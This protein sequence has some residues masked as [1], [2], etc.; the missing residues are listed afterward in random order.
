LNKAKNASFANTR[1]GQTIL[2]FVV[3]KLSYCDQ[4]FNDKLFRNYATAI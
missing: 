1:S 3:R 4:R 2:Y